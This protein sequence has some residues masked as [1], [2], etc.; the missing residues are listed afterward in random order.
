M[1]VKKALKHAHIHNK[2]LATKEF[3]AGVRSNNL[4][5]VIKSIK[6][7]A[8]IRAN[9]DEALRLSAEHGYV[10]IVA[11]LLAKGADAR[12]CEHEAWLLSAENGCT[13][14]IVQLLKGGG[15]VH[16][17]YDYA[18][19]VNARKLRVD[20]V[21]ILLEWGADIHCWDDQILKHL[22]KT[23]NE[24]LASAIL[25]YCSDADYHYFP[26]R[27]IMDNVTQTKNAAKL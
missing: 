26:D 14:V 6:C 5:L 23:F 9:N 20:I 1:T 2:K 17:N 4:H 16:A 22:Q 19:Y 15:D 10:E 7:G 3:F 11:L 27:F 12:A 21:R 13:K 24:E 25:P 8:K 18:L